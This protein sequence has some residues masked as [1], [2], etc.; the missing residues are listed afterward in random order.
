MEAMTRSIKVSDMV[1]QT[2]IALRLGVQPSTVANWRTRYS[3]F[4][5]PVFRLNYRW[6]DVKAWLEATGRTRP[7]VWNPQTK[8][9]RLVR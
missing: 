3:N 5:E 1:T 6:S 9:Y 8:R 7:Q 4:P 2:E